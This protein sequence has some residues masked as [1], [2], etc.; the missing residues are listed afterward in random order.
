M[1]T[2]DFETYQAFGL[3]KLVN[4]N[5]NGRSRA[6]F[7]ATL[8]PP[9]DAVYNPCPQ[10]FPRPGTPEGAISRHNEWAGSAV[11]PGTKRD[12]AVYTTPG[13]DKSQPANLVIVQDG[14]SFYLPPE[15][16]VRA[17][18]VFDVLCAKGEMSPTVAVFVNP[19]RLEGEPEQRSI[20]YD[21]MTDRYGRFLLEDL[22]PFVEAAE[23]VTLS[24]D[25]AR[26]TL[27]GIS[28]GGIC[29]WTAAWWF[30]NEFGRV[31]S[32]CGS[33]VNIR[34]GHNWPFIVRSTERKPIRVFLQ[35]GTHDGVLATG[36][37]PL[38]NQTMADSLAYA[39]Y[40]MRFEF[41]VGGHS[42]RHGGAIFA[43]SLRWLW[44]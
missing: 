38:A 27:I 39:G 37:W 41:G 32:H 10:A 7:V 17:T 28:S 31:L 1:T 43:E 33:F 11:Y 16:Q 42:L 29:S 36:N 34:G 6:D 12:V 4:I 24:D 44:R 35:S 25:P 30:P 15:G 40:D 19:G 13:L 3:D 26:R 9:E 8:A 5:I 22:I 20:E 21:T 14:V 2:M 18:K 23:G